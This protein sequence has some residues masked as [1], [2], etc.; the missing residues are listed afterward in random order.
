MLRSDLLW[1]VVLVILMDVA[2]A[3]APV[4]RDVG[5]VSL[6]CT[7]ALSFHNDSTKWRKKRHQPTN[8][9]IHAVNSLVDKFIH[10]TETAIHW[11][12][13]DNPPKRPKPWLSPGV[14]P[15]R[16]N[17]RQSRGRGSSHHTR[18]ISE[19]SHTVAIISFLA[20]ASTAAHATFDSDS[21][22]LHIDNCASRCITHDI[23]DFITPPR[24]VIGRVKGMG[25]DNVRVAAVGT[26]RWTIDDD[27][28]QAHTFLIPGGLYI[29]DSPARLFS[30]QHWAQQRKDNTPLPNGTWQAAY[31]DHIRL[32]WGQQQY[33]RR[34][35]YDAANVAVLHT[36]ASNR[37]FRVFNACFT[38][39]AEGET[40]KKRMRYKVFNTEIV[41]DDDNNSPITTTPHLQGKDEETWTNAPPDDDEASTSTGGEKQASTS[42]YDKSH[43]H[44]QMSYDHYNPDEQGQEDSYASANLNGTIDATAELMIWHFRMGHTP[45]SRLQNMAES[46]S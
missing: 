24:K 38:E 26:I 6:L 13:G 22:A 35:A 3:N 12:L 33:Q 14:T 11:L 27:S 19:W 23:H 7:W 41:T 42:G 1:F 25:G 29:P 44:H 9:T 37:A 15:Q 40:N 39:A 8:D 36:S 45:F 5:G 17:R 18:R 46:G 16:R 31:H 43:D 32:V 10:V 21:V 20:T 28:G 30:P 2:M 34:V 4:T